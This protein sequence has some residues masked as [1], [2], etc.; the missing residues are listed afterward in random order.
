LYSFS[1]SSTITSVP[2]IKDLRIS[3]FTAYDFPDPDFA[4]M[5]SLA[6]S[7]ENRSKRMS[8]LLC[9]FI[10]YR[11]PELELRS[12]DKKGKSEDRGPVFMVVC[13]C[14]I[15]FPYG[16]VELNPSRWR[17]KAGFR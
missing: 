1:G 16:S 9:R 17:Y 10:P 14:R 13:D 4:N 15:S 8:E 11:M 12:K 7:R 2:V 5:T 6:F 3:N